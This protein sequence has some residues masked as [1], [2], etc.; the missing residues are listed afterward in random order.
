MMHLASMCHFLLKQKAASLH[1]H[2]SE[3]L[4]LP[5][6]LHVAENVSHAC[7]VVGRD[8]PLW[9]ALQIFAADHAWEA[10]YR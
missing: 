3:V 4:R 5:E 8:F 6:A 1:G 2:G 10:C 9:N 7:G